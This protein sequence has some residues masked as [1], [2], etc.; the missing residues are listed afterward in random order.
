VDIRTLKTFVAAYQQGSFSA[1]ARRIHSTQPGVSV[2]IAALESELGVSLF[3]R[4]SRQ[5]CPT[6]AGKRLYTHAVQ[7]IQ[8]ANRAE[9]EISALS[10]T[11]SGAI[12]AGIPPTLSKA[13]LAAVLSRYVVE[14]PNV[15]IRV[16]EAYSDTL[17]SLV[18]GREVDFAFVTQVPNH[19]AI[20]FQR[21]YQDRF[22]L[23][24]GEQV[25]LDPNLPVRLDIE[26]Y[27]KFVLPSLRHGLHRL[28]SEPLQTRR[29]IT[30]RV[31]E[32][33]GLSGALEFLSMSNW[34]ALLPTAAVHGIGSEYK[35]RFSPLAG[36]E[37]KIDY[38]VAR[39]KTEAT[40]VAG[41]A[42]IK[43]TS[44]ELDRLAVD[45]SRGFLPGGAATS[46]RRS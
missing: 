6:I 10:G 14:Y 23:V 34:V 35:L 3:E 7:L 9:K 41:E 18:E 21:V 37:I 25:P 2:Q 20:T 46:T 42:F 32:L 27:F 33:D 15:E 43:I 4:K 19:P 44:S 39:A 38:F 30:E 29:I 26:P 24:Y 17:L 5:V 36:D 13:V 22:V 16:T 11:V 45:H 40:S 12:S 31:I 1:A 28:L 8:D